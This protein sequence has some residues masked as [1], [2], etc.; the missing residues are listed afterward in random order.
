ML[1]VSIVLISL[2]I[3]SYLNAQTKT[4]S[5]AFNDGFLATQTSTAH[6][7]NNI[8]S[9][10]TLGI[11]SA[12]FSQVV[13]SN[14]TQFGGSQGNDLAGTVTFFLNSGEKISLTGALNWRENSGQTIEVLGFIFNSGQNAS[15]VYTGGTFNIVGGTTS[16]VSSTLGLRVYTNSQVF[17]DGTNRSGGNAATNGLLDALNAELTNIPTTTFSLTQ[18]S[19]LEGQNLVFTINLSV[20]TTAE[21]V[22][23]FSFTGSATSG[24]DYSTVYIFSN[25]ITN[26]GDGTISIPTGVSSFTITVG[27]L[28]DDLV[29]GTE[30]LILNLGNDSSTGNILDADA[31]GFIGSNQTICPN[32]TPATL[33]TTTSAISTPTSYQWQS[34]SDNITFLNVLSGGT[35]ET[36]SPGS[37]SST[38]YFR[39]NAV[40]S[41]TTYTSN[42]VTITVLESSSITWTGSTSN[43]F[44][45]SSNWNPAVTSPTGCSVIIP[46]SSTQVPILNANTSLLSLTI[47]TGKLIDLSTNNLTLTGDFSNNGS[48]IG[49]GILIFAGATAQSISGTGFVKNVTVNNASGIS[50]TSGTLNVLGVFTPTSGRTT[51]NNNLVFKATST[52][53]G[54]IGVYGGSCLGSPTNPFDGDVIV[55]RLIPG[56]Q[57]S[58][59]FLTP[60]VTSSTTIKANWQEGGVVTTTGFPNT[61]PNG[62]SENPNPGY[63]THITGSAN[64]SNGFDATVTGNPSMFTFN[65]NQ[66]WSAINNTI[67]PTFKVGEAYRIMVRGSRAMNLN[68]NDPTPDNTIIRTKGVPAFCDVIFNTTNVAP[69]RLVPDAGGST[70]YS[71]IGNPYWSVIDWHRVSKAGVQNFYYYWDPTVVTTNR[72]GAYVTVSIDVNGNASETGGLAQSRRFLQPGQAV[73]VKSTSATPSITFSES[74]KDAGNRVNVF[75][76]NP[77][78]AGGENGDIENRRTRGGNYKKSEMIFVSLFLSQSIE[79]R[80]ADATS[81]FYNESFSNKVGNDDASKLNNLDENI[82]FISENQK[83]AFLGMNLSNEFRSDTLPI[84]MWNL[85]DQNYILRFNLTNNINPE[86]EIQL[87][88]RVTG[89]ITTLPNNSIYDYTF[90]PQTGVKTNDQFALIFNT[91]PFIPKPR[92]RKDLSIFPNPVNSSSLVSIALPSGSVKASQTNIA[93]VEVFDMRGRIVTVGR[94]QFVS[95]ESTSFDIGDLPSGSYSIRVTV[96]GKTHISSFIKQ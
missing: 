62:A 15:I 61:Y 43:S 28:N 57:R 89:Q 83:L 47:E 11:R 8:I 19:V 65:D 52:E 87:L 16:N 42:S 75:A 54:T 58:F 23:T 67:T 48:T 40:I 9:F 20:A 70:I 88:N 25:G 76:K 84:S 74:N 63:G 30:T 6:N 33:N 81:V 5:V 29:E 50:I 68:I 51:T 7:P 37:L 39:R 2:F 10:A 4:L 77:V 3:P 69:L 46:S 82:A 93:K 79:N 56:N 94:I 59:R 85:Y 41:G 45:T 53:E 72:R 12:S 90:T 44:T 73:L 32:T 38:T 26:N 18:S 14:A 35:S 31:G 24:S 64:G 96:N 34:S 78:I 95:E 71:F 66:T 91:R 60:G 55:E 27:T 21:L 49:T 80:P 92:S 13:A 1:W 17:V 86:R 22:K 36:Y